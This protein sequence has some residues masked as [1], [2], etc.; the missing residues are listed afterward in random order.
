MASYWVENEMLVLNSVDDFDQLIELSTEEFNQTLN[1]LDYVSYLE[2]L[3]SDDINSIE[4]E[5]LSV[6]LNRDQVIQIQ[7][8][9]Y[10]INKASNKI[11][12]LHR[13]YYNSYEDLIIENTSNQYI[14]EFSTEE[15]VF[16]LLGEVEDN[17]K[18]LSKKCQSSKENNNG[19]WYQ[20]ADFRDVGNIYN[21]GKDK[22]YKFKY[23]CM[24]RYDNWGIYRKLFTEFKHKEAFGGTWDGTYFSFVYRAKYIVKNGN[25]GNVIQD[26]SYPFALNTSNN[27]PTSEYQYFTTNKEIIHYRGTK[28]LKAY[29]LN[30]WIWVRSRETLKP[31]LA[32]TSGCI[33][34]NDG[35]MCVYPC[36]YSPPC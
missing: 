16:E 22:R 10:R 3:S 20:Y 18:A 24:V 21:K 33:R 8:Y 7:N 12:A 1:D 29:D 15:N 34:I 35:G 26:A 25:S 27:V 11:F 6:A 23:R 31:I 32:P 13:D 9:I 17:E 14:L 5:F 28:C 4:D 2:S 36:S 30:S 19:G